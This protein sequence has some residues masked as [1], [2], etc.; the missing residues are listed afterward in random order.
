MIIAEMTSCN[1]NKNHK[2]QSNHSIGYLD[3][4]RLAQNT[5]GGDYGGYY[6]ALAHPR[7][8]LGL[9]YKYDAFQ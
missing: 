8:F 2:G 6:H 3:M 7:Y 4:L 5:H 1:R 9:P